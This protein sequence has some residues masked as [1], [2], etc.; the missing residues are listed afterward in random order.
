MPSWALTCLTWRPANSFNTCVASRAIGVFVDGAVAIV[1]YAVT[2]IVL[3]FFAESAGITNTFIYGAVA[4]VIEPVAD[5]LF[6]TL[7]G[8]TLILAH[9]AELD[10]ISADARLAGDTQLAI[11]HNVLIYLS[12]TVVIETIAFF[13]PTFVRAFANKFSFFANQKA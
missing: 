4:I 3:R 10:S 8:I 11:A 6:L 2:P 1:I 5:L 12:I 7:V 9:D 13:R